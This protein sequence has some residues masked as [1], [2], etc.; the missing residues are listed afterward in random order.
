MADRILLP[1]DL[2]GSAK[3]YRQTRNSPALP[4]HQDGRCSPSALARF[5]VS[6]TTTRLTTR[7]QPP[8]TTLFTRLHPTLTR[9]I[10]CTS[11]ATARLPR[12]QF[13]T[14]KVLVPSTTSRMLQATDDLSSRMLQR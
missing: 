2:A 6:G 1:G 10:G 3:L 4:Q 13:N 5:P 9:R 8:L 7:I 12:L 11:S 14:P